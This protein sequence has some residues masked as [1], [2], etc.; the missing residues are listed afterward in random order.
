MLKYLIV[1]CAI[2][3]SA[4]CRN[5]A[6][7]YN[8]L[9]SDQSSD[10]QH[11]GGNDKNDDSFFNWVDFSSMYNKY[12]NYSSSDISVFLKMKLLSSI[13]S[14]AN[15]NFELGNGIRFVRDGSV[16]VEANEEF[17][18]NA[19]LKSLPRTLNEK[20]DI[21]SSLIWKRIGK[22]LRS[23]TLQVS[24]QIERMFKQMIRLIRY[25]TRYAVPSFLLDTLLLF[26]KWDT[27]NIDSFKIDSLY[28]S[29]CVN[30]GQKDALNEQNCN[31]D[32]IKKLIKT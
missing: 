5:T 16:D 10:K 8:A 2:T 18:E 4:M 21:L 6:S 25:F 23:H 1:V 3:A 20:E 32:N 28:N 24:N 13:D 19:I 31:Y 7:N 29:I 15:K 14:V 9:N 27:P 22:L 30:C 17:N 11:V 12:V 26:P